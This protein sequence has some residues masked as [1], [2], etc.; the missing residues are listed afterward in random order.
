MSTNFY[1]DNSDLQYYFEKG[2]DWEKL[3]R[4][5]E[6]NYKLEDG[7]RSYEEAQESFEDILTMFGEFVAKE[8]APRAEA[9]DRTK[10]KLENGEAIAPK[11]WDEVF[12]Q[13]KELGLHG[14]PIP[15]EFGGMNAPVL[16]YF[17]NAEMLGRAD[18]SAMTHKSFHAGI[19][20][21]L[22][23]YSFYE[24]TTH[25]DFENYKIS[26]TRFDQAIREIA[27]GEAWGCMDITEPDAGSDMAMLKT[28]AVQD[29]DGQWRLTG[30]KIFITSGHG[31][32]HVV[33]ARSEEDP[34]LGLDGLSLFLVKAYE[35]KEDGTRERYVNIVRVEE[36]L[37]HNGS[38]TCALE[39][40][41]VPAELIGKRGEG[42]KLMLLLMNNARVGVGFE[43]LGVMEASLR[44]AKDYAAERRSMGKSIDRH[45]MIADY[46]DEMDVDIHAQRAIV[47]HAGYNE[48]Y[49]QK[50]E[51]LGRTVMEHGDMIPELGLNSMEDLEKQ[52]AFHRWESRRMTPLL[53]YF[54][55][56]KAV[57]HAQRC[58]QI[59]GGAG[60]T[61]DY[62]AEKLL[63]DAM[64]LPIYEGTSQIQALMA[65][66]D[67]LMRVLK[68]P[69]AFITSLAQLRWRSL[70]ASDPLERRVCK[71]RATAMGA[72]QTLLQKTVTDKFKEVRQ[73][74][75]SQWKDA[76]VQ[77]DP[78][79]DFAF[80]MLHAERLIKL[81]CDA[82][83]AELFWEQSVQHSERRQ[84]VERWLERAEPRSRMLMDEI[85]NYG[86]RILR[87]LETANAADQAAE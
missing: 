70:S 66:K 11:E 62:G 75:M 7:P 78:K 28:R 27:A 29:E 9:I 37:G 76:F 5:T 36:K 56:E 73:L 57:E 46:L 65:M 18:V 41:N 68:N 51:M 6:L 50:L 64:V 35:D 54:G 74:P 31:K 45:E 38:A 32:Y 30:N 47:M 84:L 20:L 86:T 24:G 22:L 34:N 21:A 87:Q 83:A 15:R 8:V 4:I 10:V 85:N 17:M 19:A 69:Q 2:L 71:L 48:E 72:I 16:L 58:I 14:L 40:D 77:M 3:V 26:S 42:F 60:Y 53:K 39:F 52:I 33:I 59:H 80:A 25:F 63:R 67:N 23:V 79:R 43:C 12:D 44:A 13:I 82:T 61:K 49:A 1:K 81:L 55:A